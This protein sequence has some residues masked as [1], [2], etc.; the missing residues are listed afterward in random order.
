MLKLVLKVIS[1]IETVFWLPANNRV[2]TADELKK[3]YKKCGSGGVFH[4]YS[5]KEGRRLVLLKL[6]SI[7]S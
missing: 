5:N 3:T 4:N 2:G 1:G 6:S 7:V